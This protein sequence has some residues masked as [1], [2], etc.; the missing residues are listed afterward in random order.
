MLKGGIFHGSE[1]ATQGFLPSFTLSLSLPLSLELLDRLPANCNTV[2]LF[3]S[4]V[5]RLPLLEDS[6]YVGTMGS[7][8]IHRD[9]NLMQ[10]DFTS[11]H[12]RTRTSPP[13]AR[14]TDF[15]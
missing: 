10:Y 11:V 12:F 15:T 8:G 5:E 6:F 4:R 2:V 9:S 3:P 14:A 7:I 13:D 1:L